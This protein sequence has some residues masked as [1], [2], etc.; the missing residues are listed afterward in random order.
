MLTDQEY[1]KSFLRDSVLTVK[2]FGDQL[3]SLYDLKIY[4]MIP[5][6]QNKN[7]QN[8]EDIQMSNLSKH[9]KN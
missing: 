7:P 9:S 5:F 6:P 4:E 1:I 2:L 8:Q 3:N